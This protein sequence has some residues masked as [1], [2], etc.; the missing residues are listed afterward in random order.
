MSATTLETSAP[1]RMPQFTSDSEKVAFSAATAKS[2]PRELHEG[3][4]D[5]IAVHHGDGG[6]V[7]VVEPRPA[8]AIRRLGRALPLA[9]ILLELAEEFAQ[10]LA[11]A[12]IAAGAG[13]DD[14]CTRS[15]DLEIGERVV[16]VVMELRAHG[17]ALLRPV[18]DRPADAVA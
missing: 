3:A 4:A 14:A 18:Q 6:L 5:A 17:V 15:I 9:R 13:D 7:E 16:H 11:G 10:V 8:P 12:E 1:G 2:Q